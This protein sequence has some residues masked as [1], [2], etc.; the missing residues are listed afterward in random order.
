M[1]K[2]TQYLQEKLRQFKVITRFIA[3]QIKRAALALNA[4]IKSDM[5][6]LWNHFVLRGRNFS[7]EEIFSWSFIRSQ[8]NL[9][10]QK[11]KPDFWVPI[12]KERYSNFAQLVNNT[13]N[14][15]QKEMRLVL[16]ER[17]REENTL[18]TDLWKKKVS[19]SYPFCQNLKYF[20]S[21]VNE[22]GIHHKPFTHCR[23]VLANLTLL[24]GQQ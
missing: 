1:N 21:K 19:F 18:T 17:S 9:A 8:A 24:K 2:T 7:N 12:A 11:L 22:R 16:N 15:I 5:M 4:V 3:A 6:Y 13:N 10:L 23:K 14:R 20:I